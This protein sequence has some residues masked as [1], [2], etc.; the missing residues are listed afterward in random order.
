MSNYFLRSLT[1]ALLATLA[2]AAC[3]GNDDDADQA[4]VADNPGQVPA[5]ATGSA[6]AFSAYVAGLPA[7]DSAEPLALTGLV[8]PV[9]DTDE[10]IAMR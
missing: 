3:G 1:L 2:L 7:S 5:S 6:A 9:S 4:T 10:P 8:P